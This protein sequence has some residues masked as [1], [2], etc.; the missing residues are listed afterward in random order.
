MPSVIEPRFCKKCK[1][2]RFVKGSSE[3]LKIIDCRDCMDSK[4]KEK[5]NTYKDSNGYIRIQTGDG[6]KYQHRAVWRK[7]N[8]EI[9]EGYIIHH[10]NGDKTDNR[11]ENLELIH[12]TKH[13]QLETK[14]RWQK[15]KQGEIKEPSRPNKKTF[16]KCV[17][18][19]L[20]EKHKSLRAVAKILGTSHN[21][22]ARNLKEYGVE[23]E[24]D[25]SKH[26]TLITNY[27]E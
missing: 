16:D 22:I 3:K 4:P 9:P 5:G 25:R 24:F 1:S 13:D 12:R 6:Y 21:T 27:G 26:E 17:L 7:Q 2:F 19:D 14:K 10:K 15:I 8:G 23:Y 18:V 11:M 20:L